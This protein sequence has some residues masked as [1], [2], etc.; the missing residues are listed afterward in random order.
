MGILFEKCSVQATLNNRQ[1]GNEV[2]KFRNHLLI[3]YLILLESHTIF[4]HQGHPPCI[5]DM[6]LTN[7]TGRPYIEDFSK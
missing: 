2:S 1:K 4:P 7:S 5:S 3:T 6:T